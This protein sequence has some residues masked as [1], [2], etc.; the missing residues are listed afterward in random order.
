MAIVPRI[1]WA[2]LLCLACLGAPAPGEALD[3]ARVRRL[4]EEL[5]ARPATGGS[6]RS[7][8]ENLAQLLRRLAA[9]EASAG[10]TEE[11]RDWVVAARETLADDLQEIPRGTR[12]HLVLV[13]ILLS[14][15][16]R[17]AEQTLDAAERPASATGHVT[18]Q[19]LDRALALLAAEPTDGRTVWLHLDL[20]D[21]LLDA[22]LEQPLGLPRGYLS[23]QLAPLWELELFDPKHS[24]QE[25]DAR[26][27]DRIEA[28]VEQLRSAA[29]LVAQGKL[30]PL[31]LDLERLRRTRAE[32]R[33]RNPPRV[34][35]ADEE[36]LPDLE[37]RLLPYLEAAPGAGA[38]L[39]RY[40]QL[41]SLWYEGS[42][43]R[44]AAAEGELACTLALAD[45][46]TLA[47]GAPD[48]L[49]HPDSPPPRH[50]PAWQRRWFA[51]VLD[52]GRHDE[53][54]QDLR[55]S[56]VE[57]FAA[58]DPDPD[59]PDH[60]P[61]WLLA[62]LAN[63]ESDD[64][65]AALLRLARWCLPGERLEGLVQELAS[66]PTT[67]ATRE[68]RVTALV[69]LLRYLRVRGATGPGPALLPPG[70][71]E[72]LEFVIDGP[73][74]RDACLAV[75]LLRP[76]VLALLPRAR[77][78]GG[79]VGPV[80]LTPPVPDEALAARL[81]QRLREE[82]A[83]VAGRHLRDLLEERLALVAEAPATESEPVPEPVPE[84]KPVPEPVPE[85]E[86][87]PEPEPELA[88]VAPPVPP[89]ATPPT[90]PLWPIW[91]AL[92]AVLVSFGA[93]GLAWRSLQLRSRPHHPA[94][95]PREGTDPE[96]ATR[97]LA[98]EADLP[99]L[100][101][102]YRNLQYLGEG[103]MCRVYRAHDQ[104]LDRVV[105]VK[106]LRPHLSTDSTMRLRF[107][108]EARA[109]ASLSHP[110]IVTVHDVKR[111]EPPYF[112]M[113]CIEGE[114]LRDLLEHTG[115]LSP[116]QALGIGLALADAL[117]HAHDHGVVHRD[118]KPEN[119][120]I[121]GTGRVVLVDFGLVKV[122][123][124]E[125][126]STPDLVMGSLGYMAPE[127]IEGRPVSPRTD[128]YGLGVV[129][130]E[131]VSG[132]RPSRHTSLQ[133]PLFHPP[134]PPADLPGLP[135]G[136]ALT[137]ERAMAFAPEDRPANAVELRGELR[138][139]H[140]ALLEAAT[141]TE[142]G[143]LVDCVEVLGTLHQELV[144]PIA[145]QLEIVERWEA[146]PDQVLEHANRTRF[147]RDLAQLTRSL[148]HRI[149][150]L[151]APA[152][153]F[154]ET[155]QRLSSS[156]SIIARI[157]QGAS[158]RGFAQAQDVRRAHS[159]FRELSLHLQ[160]ILGTYRVDLAAVARQAVAQISGAA[161]IP[162]LA[163]PGSQLEV[164]LPDAEALARDLGVALEALVGSA[165][166]EGATQV[167][168][169]L[170]RGASQ[171]TV[172][173]ADD[174]VGRAEE[175]RVHGS[176][177]GPGTAIRLMGRHGGSVSSSTDGRLGGAAFSIHLPL[178][179]PA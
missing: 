147:L 153:Q 57:Y 38:W 177:S 87:L 40:D 68:V 24:T 37:D 62:T 111:G 84:P 133:M 19:Q 106:A 86:P 73:T 103:G 138:R 41:E 152:P 70:D 112:I 97:M 59:D 123:G 81:R 12:C 166:R 161:E 119:I 80:D 78:P 178:P 29:A 22:E 55:W 118:L 10:L 83:T 109:M 141:P 155:Y 64:P 51:R 9:P 33:E 107:L 18:R 89:P 49:D 58:A 90:T 169:R 39:Q 94:S 145:A 65:L 159:L 2:L 52:P 146:D 135:P 6:F 154:S 26:A 110:N 75:D 14:G 60:P 30:P 53:P 5:D 71:L 32:L 139:A 8:R 43:I 102:R 77:R 79:L 114:T 113:E 66:P 93:L 173:V 28:L 134:V 105:A 96:A 76:Q 1:R 130:Y 179:A 168:V 116:R 142:A 45:A 21:Q 31:Q 126:R 129:L 117:A 92:V 85:P 157:A 162:V 165:L 4:Q 140:G 67:P 25:Q 63:E 149:G 34:L 23:Q 156:R 104:D 72:L 108:D 7:R 3:R 27:V 151:G 82:S 99:E 125:S 167:Q 98:A 35:P 36:L 143:T 56:L 20:L 124:A 74:T 127:Q 175:T 122:Q 158:G 16:L 88:P 163:A 95:H 100:P 17:I 69:E 160:E 46:L 131:M 115:I 48:I 144:Q 120:L 121:T 137:I 54:T 174:L 171:L 164:V 172:V 42:E 44:Q 128:L 11:C 101:A 47:L 150:E 132:T 61:A 50:V 170:S 176:G 13:D 136:L 91:I 148:E 15:A